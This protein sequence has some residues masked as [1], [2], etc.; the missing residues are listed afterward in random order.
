M[1]SSLCGAGEVDPTSIHED[2][3]LIPGFVQWVGDPAFPVSCVVG[4][5]LGSD[6]TLLW[7]WCRP[8]S[9]IRPLAYELPYV[10]GAALK[11]KEKKRTCS[12]R[13]W[14]LRHLRFDETMI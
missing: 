5:R 7:V 2:E 9:P 6:P 12:G 8:K 13:Q 14:H 10:L 4:C 1:Q 11:S 3:G